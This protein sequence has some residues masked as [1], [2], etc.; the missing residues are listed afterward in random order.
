MAP[1]GANGIGMPIVDQTDAYSH[2]V[3]VG[4]P[5]ITNALSFTKTKFYDP[6]FLRYSKK[7]ASVRKLKS[8]NLVQRLMTFK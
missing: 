4:T 6:S 3:W 5:D 2:F 8:K 7:M 1:R